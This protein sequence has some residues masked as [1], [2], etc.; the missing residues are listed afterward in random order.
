MQ[1]KL[2]IG[3]GLLGLCYVAGRGLGALLVQVPDGAGA[4]LKLILLAA[5]P[6]AVVLMIRRLEGRVSQIRIL[7]T[8][9]ASTTSEVSSFAL[10]TLFVAATV[11]GFITVVAPVIGATLANA[12]GDTSVLLPWAL[13]VI[14]W[15]VVYR[16]LMRKRDGRAV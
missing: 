9:E 6:T 4:W 14:L 7:W 12:A 3:S 8:Q 5:V 10:P 2:L 11:V 15:I 13:L 16:L 1:A